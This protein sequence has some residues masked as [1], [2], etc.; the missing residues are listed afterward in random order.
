[1][2]DASAAASTGIPPSLRLIAGL[3]LAFANFMVIL[4]LTIANVS[5]PHIA[6]S[7]GI[8]LEQGAWVI[9]SYAIAEAICVP[10]TAWIAFR[11]GSVRTF[12]FSMMGFGV[13]SLLC[14]LSVSIEMLVMCRIGQGVFGAFLMPMSQTLLLRVFP[15]E[16]QNI[17]M[18][19][20]AMTLLLG[21]AFGPIIGG[22]LTD[23][24]SW[25]WI[26][27]INV[28]VALL[29]IVGGAALLRPI[30]TERRVLPIDY[31]GLVL[32]VIWVGCLQ[33]ILDTGRNHDWFGDPLIV[34]LAITSAIAFLVFV[35]WELTED[36][37]V[38]D[39]R[40]LRHRGL[41][42]SLV[43]LAISFGAYFAGFVI[44]PQWQQTW[45]G[46]T[47]YQAG[48]SSSFTAIAGLLTAPVVVFLMPRFDTRVLVSGGIIW[49]AAMGLL[50]TFWTSD[51]DFWTLTLPQFIQ[52]LGMT[53]LMLP[54]INLTLNTV[55]ENEVASAAGL[56]SFVR[57]IATAF[58]TSVSLTYWGDSQRVARNDVVAA[59]DPE[60][61]S[62]S[63]AGLGFSP[64]AGLQM[65]SNMAEVE[66]TT[67]AV[68]HVFWTTSAILMFAAA[69]IWLAPRP[70]RTGGM[71]M[72]H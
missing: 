53:F 17:G 14:G 25:H 63:I 69:L 57:T 11:F 40:V 23:N 56:Q 45:L 43:V 13:F 52:G 7:L 37:P 68:L 6:G 48:Y 62:S 59:L 70:K 33:V 72:G 1:M 44:I 71:S 27:L 32:L 50:R 67:L 35:V 30:E 20:W 47:A 34:A 21:P 61:A 10:L 58:A 49:V 4:D 8:T 2:A 36:H 51:S 16:Q 31:V 18:G 22:W 29:A 15:P 19:M 46:Y 66:S 26:F 3:T 42:V 28:P 41:S 5:I 9:T 54:I 24:W 60:A 55:D 38:V 64:E 65:L 12:L 39:L